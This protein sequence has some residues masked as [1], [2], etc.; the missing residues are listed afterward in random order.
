M[1]I[2]SQS[3][4]KQ[5]ILSAMLK[6]ITENGFHATPMSLVATEAGVAAGTIYHY[7]ANKDQL[8]SELYSHLK[9]KMGIALLQDENLS[10]AYP[11]RFS[12]FWKNLFTFFIEN[13]V[14]FKF[15]EQ[16]SNSPF[17]STETRD[18]NQVF[19]KPVIDFLAD[20]IAEGHLRPLPLEFLVESLFG[21]VVTAAKFHLAGT[22][23]ITGDLLDSVVKSSWDS[24]RTEEFSGYF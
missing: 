6:L 4:K 15:L 13:P 24:V 18:D 1:T 12:L 10:L 17:I 2:H 23:E 5:A 22:Q 16:Y 3:D 20:G 21:H 8:I 19:Y 7:F 14:E 11:Y 9:Q